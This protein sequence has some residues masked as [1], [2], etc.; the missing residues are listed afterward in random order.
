M[1]YK[2]IEERYLF[3]GK[4]YVCPLDLAMEVIGG[5]WKAKFLFHLQFGP[6]TFRRAEATYKRKFIRE[7]LLCR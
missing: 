1:E 6:S 2:P 7:P 5:K 4:E 3:C